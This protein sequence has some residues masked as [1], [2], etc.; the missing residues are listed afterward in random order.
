MRAVNEPEP[1]GE[2][3]QRRGREYAI[4]CLTPTL[5]L[6]ACGIVTW[7]L[8][9][10]IARLFEPSQ[11]PASVDNPPL[12]PGAYSMIQR[13]IGVV[14]QDILVQNKIITYE[15]A[16]DPG[17][18]YKFYEDALVRDGW[19]GRGLFSKPELT[20]EGMVF[21]WEQ[22]GID[23]FEGLAYTL[24]VSAGRT[25]AITTHVQLKLARCQTPSC[26]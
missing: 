10:W 17:A 5:L 19:G 9:T 6:L 2:Q 20:M 16:L 22:T 15:T 23:G 12:A 14:Q 26:Q 7:L 4:Q 25:A 11:P 13:E 24:H 18:V 21:E 8:V 3:T 1:I